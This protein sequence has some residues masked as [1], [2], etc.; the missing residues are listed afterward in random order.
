MLEG[1][2]EEEA[3]HHQEE[4][5]EV[6]PGQETVAREAVRLVPD[7][8]DEPCEEQQVEA[9]TQSLPLTVTQ[10]HLTG[11]LRVKKVKISFKKITLRWKILLVVFTQQKE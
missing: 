3:G 11:Q 8:E 1:E 6:G 5:G 2:V 7:G 10:A 9:E 4:G